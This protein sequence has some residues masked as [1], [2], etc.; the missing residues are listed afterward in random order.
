MICIK[1]IRKALNS[2]TN[3]TRLIVSGH[4][5]AI[6]HRIEK[7]GGHLWKPTMK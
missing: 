5:N 6:V 2:E 4:W 3:T 7:S 1:N